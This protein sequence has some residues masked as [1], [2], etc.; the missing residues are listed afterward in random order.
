MVTSTHLGWAACTK[1]IL[2]LEVTS[3]NMRNE[4]KMSLSRLMPMIM[5]MP[6]FKR[7]AYAFAFTCSVATAGGLCP[8][9]STT[10]T[11]F[12]SHSTSNCSKRQGGRCSSPFVN[13]SCHSIPYGKRSVRCGWQTIVSR[14]R[15]LTS[16]TRSNGEVFLCF[17]NW[18]AALTICLLTSSTSSLLA[19]T[20]CCSHKQ[21]RHS[22]D[23]EMAKRPVI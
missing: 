8:M 10:C 13:A 16:V 23:N 9:S 14:A 22:Y 21:K 1:L 12:P 5:R 11:V 15:K 6:L 17:S 3:P 18:M 4:L 7:R 2:S 19:S 20:N